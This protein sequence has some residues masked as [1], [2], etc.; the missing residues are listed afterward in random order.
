M[1]LPEDRRHQGAVADFSIRENITLPTLARNRAS[2]GLPRPSRRS[3]QQ[4]GP[5]NYVDSLAISSS[6]V[7]Q[8]IRQLSRAAT[9]RR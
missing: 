3:E 5:Q 6:S 2:P 8:P 4:G 9:S 1:L 7:E